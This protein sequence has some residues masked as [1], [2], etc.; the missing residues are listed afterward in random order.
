MR[1]TTKRL[2]IRPSECKDNHDIFEILS[3]AKTMTFFVEG[4]YSMLQVEELLQK[5]IEKT[6]HYSLV[7]P[8]TNKVIGKLSFHSWFMDQTYEIGWIM[9][10]EYTNQGYMTEAVEAVLNYGFDTLKLH[11]V[12]ATCQP[13]NIASKRLCEKFLR[14]EGTFLQCINYKDDIWWD[15]LFYAILQSEY[16]KKNNR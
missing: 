9:N 4:T 12:I 13:E 15:E 16:E 10:Q 3:N 6:E 7:L 5:N 14:L 11:R 1:L 2:L 8:E